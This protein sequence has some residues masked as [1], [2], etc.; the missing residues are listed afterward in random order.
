MR[1]SD[2]ARIFTLDNL[3]IWRD[4]KPRCFIP[5]CRGR[6][7][8]SLW[9]F[10]SSFVALE[11]FWWLRF[12]KSSPRL[13]GAEKLPSLDILW[14]FYHYPW[15]T[16]PNQHNTILKVGWLT[17][18]KTLRVIRKPRIFLREISGRKSDRSWRSLT[19]M[20]MI[21]WEILGNSELVSRQSIYKYTIAMLAYHAILVA[22]TLQFLSLS[23][24]ELQYVPTH[25]H[26]HKHRQSNQVKK[27]VAKWSSGT[28]FFINWYTD[29]D[30]R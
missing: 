10:R 30:S 5:F 18:S 6:R 15:D 14:D 22:N 23:F 27:H 26:I 29:V 24:L 28:A 21:K 13:L 19:N 3:S 16:H 4:D 2:A 9:E 11:P 7:T 12:L 17:Q 25:T 1:I 8:Y 20:E